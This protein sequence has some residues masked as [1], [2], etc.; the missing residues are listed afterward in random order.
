MEVPVYDPNWRSLDTD[1]NVYSADLPKLSPY[2]PHGQAS[3]RLI[4][5]T[6]SMGSQIDND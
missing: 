6:Q 2:C 3:V 4:L 1:T 5:L